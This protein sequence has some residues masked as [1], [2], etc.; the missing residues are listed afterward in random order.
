MV[1]TDK[2]VYLRC[3]NCGSRFEADPLLTRCPKC[4]GLLEVVVKPI[5]ISRRSLRG[6]GV[7]VWGYKRL[8]PVPKGIRPITLS[9]GWTPLVR[10][11]KLEELLGVKH[12]YVKFEGANPTG[13]FK[14][15]GMTVAVSLAW[16]IGI[17]DYMI[18]LVQYFLAAILRKKDYLWVLVQYMS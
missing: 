3:I 7:G 13:S 8:L 4:N 14:D 2:R 5:E 10:S 6:K 11:E 9:E 1:F 17:R 16:S 15:R 12:V 18:L